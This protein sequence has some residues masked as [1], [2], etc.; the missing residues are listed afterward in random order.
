MF[1]TGD[2]A[3]LKKKKWI[4]TE[5][6]QQSFEN[7]LHALSTAPGLHIADPEGNYVV[8]TDASGIGVAGCLYEMVNDKLNPVWYVS[9]KFSTAERNYA[10]R[11][12]EQ[13][14][15]TGTHRSPY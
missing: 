14:R 3:D 8:E 9:H 6:C 7:T 10:P 2:A 1:I 11:D 4:W 5:A 13:S 12:Q 15:G